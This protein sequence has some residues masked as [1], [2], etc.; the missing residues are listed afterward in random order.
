MDRGM[1]RS[2]ATPDLA[3]PVA[4]SEDASETKRACPSR[5]E[6]I[7][8]VAEQIYS[9]PVLNNAHRGDV[10]E[11]Q[12][13]A[14]L[15]K[16]WRLV[17]LGW[18]PWD[19]QRGEGSD[20]IRIQVKQSAALQ[21]WGRTKSP[22]IVFGWKPKPPSY[23]KR[24]NPGQEIEAEGWFCEIFVVGI[25]QGVHLRDVDQVDPSQWRFLVI[26]TCD[27]QPK[28]NAMPL[29]KALTRWPLVRW[30]ELSERVE[31][32]IEALRSAGRQA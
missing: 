24:D 19:L 2:I 7:R 9:N 22:M 16:P 27:L 18:H 28:T 17:T 4:S 5:D 12:V 3:E 30:H 14:A 23:F 32:A 11:M 6:I 8:M 1:P 31:R 25:H 20:R 10:V 29:T 26:P 15:G 21:L 13:L